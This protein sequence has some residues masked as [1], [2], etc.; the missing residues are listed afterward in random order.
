MAS[1]NTKCVM[2]IDEALPLGIITNTV[3][4][5]GITLGKNLPQAVG[6]DTLDQTGHEHAGIIKIPIPILKGTGA[7]I[8]KLRERLYSEDFSDLKVVDFSDTA[9]SC[10]TYEEYIEKMAELPETELTYFG[11]SAGIRKK[12]VN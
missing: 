2:V 8:R 4:V 11:Q 1:K 3:A 12:S 6:S 5:M 9:Q 10:R 7:S